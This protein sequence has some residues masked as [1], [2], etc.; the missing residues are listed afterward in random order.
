MTS[1]QRLRVGLFL[2]DLNKSGGIQRVAVNLARDLRPLFDTCLITMCSGRNVFEEPGIPHYSLGLPPDSPPLDPR[3]RLMLGLGRRL[4]RLAIQQRL[5]AVICFWF[6]L[7]VIG[8]LALPS[9]V[10]KIGYEHIAFSAAGGRWAQIRRWTYPQLDA[11]VSLAKDDAP[12]FARIARRAEVIPNY[13]SLPSNTASDEREKILLAVGHIEH[14]KGLDRLLW[15]LQG[16][17]H[18]QREWRLALVGGGETG[19]GDPGYLQ[20]LHALV[21]LLDLAGRVVVYTAT[22]QID[23]WY[24]RASVMVMGSRLEG[25]PLVLLEAKSHGLPVIAFDCPTGPKEIV[26]DGVDGFLVDSETEFSRSANALMLDRDLRMRMSR[27]AVQDVRERFLPEIVCE[28]WQDLILDLH[29][30]VSRGG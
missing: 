14:R 7:A 13:V 1:S 22:P 6:H 21:G 26:R 16:P 17:L 11:V 8:A 29:R 24:Q 2:N 3:P 28:R 19:T 5:D 9:R 12:Q 27:C 30:R 20:Y 10:I 23:A 18:A 25:F 15:A 4:R